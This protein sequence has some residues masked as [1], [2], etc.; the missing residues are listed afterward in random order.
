MM[1]AKPIPKVVRFI[2]AG[3]VNTLFGYIAFAGLTALGWPDF[4]AVSVAMAVGAV[5]NFLSYGKLV[6]ASL[7]PRCLPRFIAA[8]LCLY[9][10]NVMGLRALARLGLE[11]YGAQS[12]LVFPLAVLAYFLNDRW[13]FRGN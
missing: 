4:L 3:T 7:D 10:C 13:V 12:V 9:A 5:F 1:D 2:V 11:A 8:Y 6:F